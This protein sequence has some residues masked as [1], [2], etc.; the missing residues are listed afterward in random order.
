MHHGKE[1]RVESKVQM[2]PILLLLP[3]FFFFFRCVWE[4]DVSL[5]GRAGRPVIPF[6][7]TEKRWETHFNG[8][9]ISLKCVEFNV[10]Y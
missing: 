8:Q 1:N 2:I 7:S 9:M 10:L 6:T 3:F 4:A 5:S